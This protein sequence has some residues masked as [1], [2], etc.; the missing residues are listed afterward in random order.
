[1]DSSTRIPLTKSDGRVPKVNDFIVSSKH[2]SAAHITYIHRVKEIQPD[3]VILLS[4]VFA[5]KE[6]KPQLFNYLT[7]ADVAGFF[8]KRAFLDENFVS[9][10][11]QLTQW[12]LQDPEI[13]IDVT[14]Y[15]ALTR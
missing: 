14:L 13:F 6:K 9:V 12:L 10:S 8:V 1:M 15:E 11:I 2:L 4:T 3:G 5:K 7:K